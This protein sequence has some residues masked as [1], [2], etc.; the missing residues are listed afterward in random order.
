MN[1]RLMKILLY[2]TLGLTSMLSPAVA[3]EKTSGKRNLTVDDYFRIRDVS[4]PQISPDGGWIAYTVTR[5]DLKEDKSDSR[6]W[7][8]PTADGEAIP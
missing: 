3:E 8:V 4:D 1:M 7:M 6:I 5:R 2:I